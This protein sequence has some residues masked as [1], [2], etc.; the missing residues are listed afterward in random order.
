LQIAQEKT[1][2]VDAVCAW[3][4]TPASFRGSTWER[5]WL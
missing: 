1:A 3:S 5:G 4:H 2:I